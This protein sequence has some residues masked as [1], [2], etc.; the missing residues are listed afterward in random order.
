MDFASELLFDGDAGSTTPGRPSRRDGFEFTSMYTPPPW[1]WLIFRL[2]FADVEARYT[3]P[4][5]NTIGNHI[6][7]SVEGVGSFSVAV[8]NL[9]PW[10]GSLQLE[11]KGP[12]PLIENNTEEAPSTTLLNGRLGY[13][14]TKNV[15]VTLDG[16]NLLN[17]KAAN[18]EY[19]YAS[20]LAGE[21]AAGVN[22]VH[23]HPVEPLT[24]RLGMVYYF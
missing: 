24:F 16:I 7:G 11:Y 12:Y 20:R 19:Y 6:P 9:G 14:I 10:F 15:V 8:N 4:N 18:I 23:F 2:D 13:R 17:S 3:G 21:P 22:D 5:P 1:Q